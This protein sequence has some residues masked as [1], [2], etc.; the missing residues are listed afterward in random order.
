MVSNHKQPKFEYVHL[1]RQPGEQYEQRA[2][3]TLTAI[4]RSTFG[5]GD[6]QLY[7]IFSPSSNANVLLL[8]RM[9]KSMPNKIAVFAIGYFSVNA[10]NVPL[11]ADR[12]NW[13]T[14]H[15][16]LFLENLEADTF[17]VE[18]RELLTVEPN[19][20]GT[21]TFSGRGYEKTDIGTAAFQLRRDVYLEH[22]TSR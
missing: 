5:L 8:N 16:Q 17:S 20:L 6:E 3:E 7:E 4:A 18:G 22:L 15:V 21:N 10:V 19:F 1:H 14:P 12:S 9:R 2:L 13:N 11:V